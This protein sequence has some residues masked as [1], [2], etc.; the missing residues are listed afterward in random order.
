MANNS[1][2]RLHWRKHAP[3]DHLSRAADLSLEEDGIYLRLLDYYWMNG[4]IP[5]DICDATKLI[6]APKS[7]SAAVGGILKRFF[8]LGEGGYTSPLLDEEREGA[9][10]LIL[11]RREIGQRGGRK[12][13][14]KARQL[15]DQLVEQGSTRQSRAGHSTTEHD[16]LSS[17]PS[18]ESD[19][20]ASRESSTRAWRAPL[21]GLMIEQLNS[22]IWARLAELRSDLTPAEIRI[23]AQKC[24]EHHHKL[25]ILREDWTPTL[26]DWVSRERPQRQSKPNAGGEV[27]NI[28]GRE[29]VLRHNVAGERDNEHVALAREIGVTSRGKLRPE[30]EQALRAKLETMARE[31]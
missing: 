11:K 3:G 30:L 29:Y 7:K 16:T 31:Q 12:S 5:A 28:D 22:D 23:C 20:N 25:G 19:L 10:A 14:T 18:R 26:E 13:Q 8:V 17:D 9:Q 27:F 1:A 21:S 6:R 24:A 15:L 2:S 4:Q